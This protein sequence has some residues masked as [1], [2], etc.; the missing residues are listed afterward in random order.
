MQKMRDWTQHS[1]TQASVK[2]TQADIPVFPQ[3]WWLDIAIGSM[4]YREAQV[5]ENEVKIGSL[6]Y[7]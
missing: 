4:H 1:S 2:T 6:L 7:I 3:Q 5:V